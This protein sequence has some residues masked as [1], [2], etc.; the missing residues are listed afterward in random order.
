MIRILNSS[1]NKANE[2]K[3]NSYPKEVNATPENEEIS[4]SIENEKEW[5]IKSNV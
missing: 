1:K 4:V 5:K 2:N 3:V